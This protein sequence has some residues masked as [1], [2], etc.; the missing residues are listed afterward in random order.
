MILSDFISRQAHNKSNP[1]D[2]IPI[3]FH[4]YNTSYD[5]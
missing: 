2:V 5:N 1:H 3:S 4:M